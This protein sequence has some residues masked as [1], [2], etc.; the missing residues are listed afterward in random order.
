[1]LVRFCTLSRSS[2][3]H[4][5]QGIFQA[6]IELRDAGQLEKY[7]E[8][9]LEGELGWLRANLPSPDCLQKKVNARAIC[10][11]KPQAK[12]AIEKVRGIVALLESRGVHVKMITIADPGTIIYQDEWQIVA[13]PRRGHAT[14]GFQISRF[15]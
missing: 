9:W 4:S 5:P 12:S 14:S 7:E 2:R 3:S 10:W 15:R 1:M 11:F 8:A 13:K 6:A